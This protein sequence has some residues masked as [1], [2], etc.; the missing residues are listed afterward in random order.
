MYF[1][2]LKSSLLLLAVAT[3]NAA[4]TPSVNPL[5]FETSSISP[6]TSLTSRLT[7]AIFSYFQPT[8]HPH[9]L[10]SADHADWT[11]YDLI[12]KDEHFTQLAKLVNYSSDSTKELLKDP[13]AK[14]T[15]FAPVNW[16]KEHHNRDVNE[17]VN[18]QD[19]HA[20][21]SL[22][23]AGSEWKLVQDMLD[24]HENPNEKD[25]DGEDDDR[26]RKRLAH[27]VDAVLLYHIVD[28]KHLIEARE[29]ADNSTVAT[30]LSFQ[31]KAAD[32]VGNWNDGQPL[33]IRVGKSLIPRPGIYLN[34]YDKVVYADI[35]LKNGV[36]HAVK[37]PLF[38]SPSILQG[39]FW[40]QP[41]FGTLSSALQK[42]NIEGYL[43]LPIPKHLDHGHDQ[44]HRHRKFPHNGRRG[45]IDP[46]GSAAAT[47]FAPDNFAW[48]RLP[49]PFQAYLFS[50]W[51]ADLLGKILM[52]HSIPNDVF[53]ADSVHHVSKH[54]NDG[55]DQ[56]VTTSYNEPELIAKLWGEHE[57]R[58]QSGVNITR[59]TFDS[60]LP[61]LPRDGHDHG[62]LPPPGEAKEF[63]KVDVEVWRYY[64]LPGGKGPLQTAIHVQGVRVVTP[65]IPHFNGATHAIS[66]F[67]RP[68]GHPHRGVWA[69]VA[70]EA[71]AYGF[72][73]VD[74]E[75]EDRKGGM[76]AW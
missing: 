25:H 31:G 70:R 67:I 23:H 18:G 10:S 72:G 60:V 2:T 33:R 8:P 41:A 12:T 68:R 35:H 58:P 22:S 3:T 53:Y 11:I 16:H 15:I 74:L 57:A 40:S 5:Y 28:S 38:Q 21:A 9:T 6:S 48:T 61:K 69:E 44:E 52:L 66:R 49:Y 4:V 76:E 26:R 50:P 39:L 51:G 14:L 46:K 20:A 37:Y 59:Y 43:S 7:S 29:L 19:H 1:P 45:F 54:G 42:L 27:I 17:F 47:L 56:G 75:A 73:A 64:L 55:R 13:E 65:D 24:A 34:F 36:A 30:K 32:F 63:E 71:E 62:E